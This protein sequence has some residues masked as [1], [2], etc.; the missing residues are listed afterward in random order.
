MYYGYP[1]NSDGLFLLLVFDAQKPLA[2]LVI[3]ESVM[4]RFV[5]N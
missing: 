5:L 4:V 1:D 3:I 2:M